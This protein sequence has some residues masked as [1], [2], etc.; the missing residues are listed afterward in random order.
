VIST[1]HHLLLNNYEHT[2]NV[3]RRSTFEKPLLLDLRV[4][5]CVLNQ[6]THIHCYEQHLFANSRCYTLFVWSHTVTWL[7]QWWYQS[8]IS[9]H[10]TIKTIT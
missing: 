2:I 8:V 9:E 3:S 5:D 1:L 7:H 4:S 10:S 6:P